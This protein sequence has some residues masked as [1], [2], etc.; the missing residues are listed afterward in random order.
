MRNMLCSSSSSSSSCANEPP[1]WHIALPLCTQQHRH[2]SNMC[3][4][5]VMEQICLLLCNS[6]LCHAVLPC[7]VLCSGSPVED[8][9]STVSQLLTSALTN[10]DAESAAYWAYHLARTGFFTATVGDML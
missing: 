10:G 2:L 1:G 5:V 3:S 4:A 9:P 7:T 8:I 6:V